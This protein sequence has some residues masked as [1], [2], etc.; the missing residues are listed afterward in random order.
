M[1]RLRVAPSTIGRSRA[2]AAP[3]G[4]C[5]VLTRCTCTAYVR[6]WPSLRWHAMPGDAAPLNAGGGA[7]GRS[8]RPLH[9]RNLLALL[10][11]EMHA[12]RAGAACGVLATLMRET[13]QL[14]A[15]LAQAGFELLRQEPDSRAEC[16]RWAR[17]FAKLDRANGRAIQLEAVGELLRGGQVEE[18]CTFLKA[19]LD[20]DTARQASVH[21]PLLHGALGLALHAKLRARPSTRAHQGPR[22]VPRKVSRASLVTL[23]GL[24]CLSGSTR[25]M[26]PTICYG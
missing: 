5:T 14:T 21:S 15:P 20:N 26:P 10:Q 22:R 4:T 9:A 13:T 8:V 3:H 1:P 12:R 19:A 11:R 25:A 16:E 6:R 7:G 18:A 24:R 17:R 2:G 23:C